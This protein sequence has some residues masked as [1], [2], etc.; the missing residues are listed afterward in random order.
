[1]PRLLLTGANGHLGRRLIRTLPDHWTITAVVRS[2]RAQRQL[3][4]K[5]GERPG[6]DVTLSDPSDAAALAT[7]AAGADVAVHLIGTIKERRDNRY[8]DSHQRPARAL[9][10]AAAQVGLQRVIYLSIL[11]ASATSKIRCLRARAAV[12]EILQGISTTAAT[13]IRVPM[14]LGEGDRASGALARRAATDRVFLYRAGSLEQP[15]YAGDVVDALLAAVD[16]AAAAGKVFEL[17]GPESLPRGELVRRAA[18]TCGRRPAVYSLPLILG[19]AIA[20]VME[21]LTAT[22][23]VTR[24]MLR[25]LDHDDAIDPGPAAAALGLDL[26]PLDVMLERCV[27]ERCIQLTGT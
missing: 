21:Q 6:L 4:R 20:G 9:A 24:D 22:P 1:M 13:V 2:E 14:V 15:I 11:G 18:A 17:A 27:K 26:T 23:R 12:E 5:V 3:T 19:L 10:A 16:R 25:V 8:E 7:L